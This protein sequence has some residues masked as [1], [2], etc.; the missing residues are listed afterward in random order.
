MVREIL[1]QVLFFLF[2]ILTRL[3]VVGEENIPV[4][5]GCL[6]AANHLSRLDAPLIFSLLKR[7]DSTGLIADKYKTYPVFRWIIEGAQGIWLDRDNPDF[8]ALR[9]AV[10]YLRGGMIIGIA[11]EGT[12]SS[13]GSLMHPKPGV[14]FLAAKANVPIVP[15]AIIGTEKT[16]GAMLRL[17]RSPVRVEFG[18]SF[19]LPH[20]GK[21]RGRDKDAALNQA[22][23][24]IMCQIAKLLPAKYW[25]VYAEHPRLFELLD[26]TGIRK[27]TSERSLIHD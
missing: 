17:R 21:E 2:R 13:T 19:L 6:L 5:G 25:G 10:K 16:I 14:A 4:S 9:M 26:S 8:G 1:R 12:R 22:A 3:E 11:P 7:K 24:E 20:P 27:E 15:V 23:D 18:A